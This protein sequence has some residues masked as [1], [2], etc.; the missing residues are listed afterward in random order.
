MLNPY[1][2]ESLEVK[3]LQQI[4]EYMKLFNINWILKR[5]GWQKQG[6]LG[7]KI[8]GL[9]DQKQVFHVIQWKIIFKMV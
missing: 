3:I 1:R 9:S 4:R 8:A 7:D 6:D 2:K 5:A